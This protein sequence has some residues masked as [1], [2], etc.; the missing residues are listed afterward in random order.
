MPT[1]TKPVTIYRSNRS[2]LERDLGD[3]VQ[4]LLEDDTGGLKKPDPHAVRRAMD[5]NDAILVRDNDLEGRLLAGSVLYH[6]GELNDGRQLFEFGSVSAKHCPG[7]NLLPN[8]SRMF[9]TRISVMEPE[10][11]IIGVVRMDSEIQN[12]GSLHQLR[13][14]GYKPIDP[15]TF[16]AVSFV[17]KLDPGREVLQF[18]PNAACA[19]ARMLKATIDAGP[20]PNK[21]PDLPT[22]V[23]DY[24]LSP[25]ND[26]LLESFIKFSCC[27][28]CWQVG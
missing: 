25:I 3:L 15:T 17:R 24:R 4:L 11:V 22:L 16:D 23:V 12:K 10:S 27:N 14:A 18:D 21:I 6:R 26:G 1:G 9:T 20:I 28:P 7:H 13:K 5:S 2:T 19:Q 8:M